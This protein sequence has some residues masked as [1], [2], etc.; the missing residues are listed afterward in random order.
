LANGTRK[1]AELERLVRKTLG[2]F[3]S[4]RTRLRP[5]IVPVILGAHE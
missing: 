1:R 3:V 2:R 4:N 5:A